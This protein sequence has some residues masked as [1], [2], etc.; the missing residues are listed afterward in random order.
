MGLR[1]SPPFEGGVP[2]SGEV[3]K[4]VKREF[5]GNGNN[6]LNINQVANSQ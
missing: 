2:R 6:Q 5:F 1:H 3:V 4:I